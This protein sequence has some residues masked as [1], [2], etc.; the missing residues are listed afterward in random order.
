MAS[1][2][3]PYFHFVK[4]EEKLTPEWCKK[5]VDYLYWNTN[6]VNLV[7]GKNLKEIEDYATGSFD[8]RPYKRM[9]KSMRKK[10]DNIK[11]NPDGTMSRLEQSVNTTG[12]DFDHQLALIPIKMNSAVDIIYKIPVD[13]SCTAQDALAMKR[14]KE[15][16]EFLK[17]KPQI[18][19]DL[20][21]LAE[22]M[23]IDQIDLG[24]T[25]NSFV[26]YANA[27]AGID[28]EDPQQED[29]FT[30][31]FYALDVEMAFEKAFEQFHSLRS[32]DQIKLLLIND[33][34][35]LGVGVTRSYESAFTALPS[36][37]YIDPTS[38]SAPESN[39]PDYS[40]NTHRIVDMS[41]TV[42]E[43]YEYFGDE[44]CD[45]TT[46][47][48]VLNEE[49]KGYCACNKLSKVD[50]KNWSQFRVNFKYIE[51]KSVDWVGIRTKPKSKRN[52]TY[53]T[54][55]EDECS[56]KIWGQNT[57]GFYW[58][59]A[60]NYFFGIK[61][62]SNTFRS[63]GKEQFQNF[64]TCIYRAQKKSAVELAIP[65]NK[66]AQIAEIKLQ[67]TLIKSLPPGRYI[68]VRFMREAIE[69]LTD[70]L[71][72]F[73]MDDLLSLVF[74]HN[75]M[76]G[77]TS[78]FDNAHDGQF[79]PFIDIPGGLKD[80]ARGY[81]NVILNS[82][83]NIASITGI[84]E[85]LTG[86]NAEELVGLQQLR[87]NSS[88][89]AIDY[90]N[91][92]IRYHFEC[93]N[94]HW[95]TFIQNAIE[96]GG[97][98]RQAIVDMIGDRNVDILDGLDKA[99]LHSLTI[100]VD[101]GTRYKQ[102]QLFQRQLDILTQKGVIST[103]DQYVLDAI[104]NP[105]ERLQKL[106]YIEDKF[107]KQQERQRAESI[108]AAQSL[109]QQRGQNALAVKQQDGQQRIGEIYAKGDVQSKLMNL[110]SSLGLSQAQMDGLIKRA[111]QRER[112]DGQT[113]KKIK[114]IQAKY[115]LDRQQ[116]IPA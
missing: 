26:K 32:S 93:I 101:I 65:E 77:D 95:A 104:E 9:F 64:S 92:G 73:T 110:G 89:N 15:D 59:Y 6:N 83:F 85:Q 82:S 70:D 76:L 100:K 63:R 24:T 2:H 60:T 53:L 41:M 42:L 16:I 112:N 57:Y 97:K 56:G 31:L 43:M 66:K 14:R 75:I 23:D 28:L 79:K 69:G 29:I 114:E 48:K 8:M 18:E 107:N 67:H 45:E 4:P 80:E 5:A 25:Q 47:E 10:L 37:D 84:N 35:K 19:E 54:S 22:R 98:T 39:L 90:C 33:Y 49:K 3:I 74:E 108:A 55:N 86:Q 111:L 36:L 102:E 113:E 11:S 116:P 94:N 40:D 21:D 17:K 68:D 96:A 38:V 99:P 50:A 91:H 72:K 81:I 71:N 87:I 12:I 1:I 78:E 51:V 34:F 30:K 27:P 103:V 52:V 88:L 13:A 7:A 62:L 20:S 105:K 109:E 58:L 106:Y 46:L 44:I 61:R 115:D